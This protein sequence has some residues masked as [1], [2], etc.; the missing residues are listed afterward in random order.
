MEPPGHK[1]ICLGFE[2]EAHYRQVVEDPMMFRQFL[3]AS[4]ASYPEL[5]PREM[6][7]GFQLH[8]SYASTKQELRVRRI[9]L[10]ASG[11]VFQIRPSFVMPYMSAKTDEIEKALYLRQW[12]VPFEALAYVFGRD[13]MY[14][15]RVWLALGRPSLVGTTV[16]VAENLPRDLVADEK[17]SWVGG[18]EV[19]LPTTVGG[20]CV[21]GLSVVPKADRENL[22]AGYGQFA[23][24]AAQ[25]FPAYEPRSVC[26]DGWKATR[27]AWR[28]LFPSITLVLCFLHSILKIKERCTG[29]DR[30]QVLDQAW[31]VYH[32]TT[33]P[34]FAQRT[35]RLAQW[36]RVHLS[37]P[38]CEVVLK[39]CRRRTDFTP[40]YDCPGAARTSN[41]VDRLLN[42][43][44][45]VLYAMRYCHSTIPQARLAVR[46]WAMQW[47]FHPYGPR[48]RHDQ[49]GRAS[50]FHDLNGFQYHANWLHNFLIASSMGG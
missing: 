22:E 43:L 12:G 25:V 18:Q 10:K 21:L 24:E 17:I 45:R 50:P 9:K 4:V 3:Q 41:A 7:G 28:R 47:N 19:Y 34:Q 13:A 31:H 32:A 49:P 48:L 15:Y 37:G 30:H 38:L 8:G 40:A 1:S 33:R 29:L 11:Q 46:A 39:L 14:W 5:F 16:K 26:T 23:A 35:R 36:A 44:D 42:H 6:A 27:Q 20:G 2:S